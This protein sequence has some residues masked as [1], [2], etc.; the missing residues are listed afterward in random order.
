MHTF[1][2]LL[3]GFKSAQINADSLYELMITF[4]ISRLKHKQFTIPD[5]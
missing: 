1:N 5:S 2:G 4:Y 3:S